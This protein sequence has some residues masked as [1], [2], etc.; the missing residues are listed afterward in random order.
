[1]RVRERTVISRRRQSQGEN[2]ESQGE[3]DESKRDA[4]ENQGENSHTFTPLC[5]LEPMK[6]TADN[7]EPHLTTLTYLPCIISI[8]K[9]IQILKTS[10]GKQY[11]FR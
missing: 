3:G 8:S 4:G 11:T 10:S 2:D 7:N 5:I 6:R 1:M 9:T